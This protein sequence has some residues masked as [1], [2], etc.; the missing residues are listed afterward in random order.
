MPPAALGQE[1][2]FLFHQWE[3]CSNSPSSSCFL[4]GMS[5]SAG[6][7]PS[8]CNLFLSGRCAHSCQPGSVLQASTLQCCVCCSA[9][10]TRG[11]A[12]LSC[13]RCCNAMGATS[14]RVLRVL[15]CCG[16]CKAAGVV[17]SAGTDTCCQPSSPS[18]LVLPFP[19]TPSMRTRLYLANAFGV[20]LTYSGTRAARTVVIN[21]QDE[22]LLLAPSPLKSA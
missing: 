7:E 16:C 10:G 18:W 22:D 11:A 2:V 1:L 3:V 13:C 20:N 14:L 19:A 8:R 9:V 5:V 21:E 4:A 17:G 15:Q 12:M 6:P